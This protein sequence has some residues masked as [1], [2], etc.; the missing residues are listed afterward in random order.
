[1]V[2]AAE[3]AERDGAAGDVADLAHGL[4]R[5]LR[6]GQGALGLGQQQ[7]P[8]LGELQPPPRAREQRHAELRLEPADLLG[9][10]RLGHV[11]RLRG[12]AERAVLRRSQEIG[13]L[14]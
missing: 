13:Q 11:Q 4:L 12:G 9:H 2:G 14:L 6:G 5:R 1:V 10:A 8:R 7:P 3:R